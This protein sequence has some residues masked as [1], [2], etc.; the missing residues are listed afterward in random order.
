MSWTEA[1]NRTL[2]IIK[3]RSRTQ[4]DILNDSDML[5]NRGCE[6]KAWLLQ[7]G[8]DVSH[9]AILDDMDDVLPEQ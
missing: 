3:M 4:N 7:N 6:I 2:E 9:Y 8:K 1:Y 5:Y